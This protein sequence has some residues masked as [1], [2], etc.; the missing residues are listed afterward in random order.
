MNNMLGDELNNLLVCYILQR[1]YLGPL[2]EV[3]YSNQHK[4][5][6]LSRWGMNLANEV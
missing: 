1:N 6:F 4:A 3:I 5:V 2:G